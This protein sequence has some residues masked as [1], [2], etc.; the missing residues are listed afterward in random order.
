MGDQGP[1][2]DPEHRGLQIGLILLAGFVLGICG[3]VL[4]WLD[5]TSVPGAVLVGAGSWAGS[6]VL[7]LAV[8]HFAQD[9]SSN[10]MGRYESRG[11]N[12]DGSVAVETL[13]Q[14]DERELRHDSE[15][16]PD[17]GRSVAPNCGSLKP[18]W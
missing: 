4:A 9:K 14:L 5:S 17:L 7:L 3:G 6:V 16:L 12:A 18:N 8:L 2:R 15:R 11:N 10:S 1:S 13:G